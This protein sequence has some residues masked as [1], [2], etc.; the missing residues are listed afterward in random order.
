MDG[1]SAATPQRAAD[2]RCGLDAD[3]F[4]RRQALEDAIHKINNHNTTQ[5]QTVS[6]LSFEELYRRVRR[7]VTPLVMRGGLP[8]RAAPQ[9]AVLPV[10]RAF[11]CAVSV[12]P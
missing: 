3:A 10:R 4:A 12:A 7:F 9:H 2:I 5:A 1:E 8:M 6:T 11:S